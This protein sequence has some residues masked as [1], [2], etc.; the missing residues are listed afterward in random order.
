MPIPLTRWWSTLEIDID[1]W[2]GL[3]SPFERESFES[4]KTKRFP[5]LSKRECLA[6][7]GVRCWKWIKNT[8]FSESKDKEEGKQW[9]WSHCIFGCFW[10]ATTMIEEIL[11]LDFFYI[12]GGAR[13][14]SSALRF[15]LVCI[16]KLCH[17]S[18]RLCFIRHSQLC[19]ENIFKLFNGTSS[20]R[21]LGKREV[22]H[23]AKEWPT[24][25]HVRI[26][27]PFQAMPE[28]FRAQLDPRCENSFAV[29]SLYIVLKNN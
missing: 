12:P 25:S 7:F 9:R 19:K 28:I 10:K 1:L 29:A 5:T 20:P 14:L 13:F 6:V 21:G 4:T 8:H 23:H 15:T 2:E 18:I 24:V 22:T 27:S 11:H 17:L 16:Q 26:Q 3:D